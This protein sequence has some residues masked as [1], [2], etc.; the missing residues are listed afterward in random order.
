DNVNSVTYGAK[1]CE[2]GILGQITIVGRQ[3][4][5]SDCSVRSIAP[6]QTRLRDVHTVREHGRGQGKSLGS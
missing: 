2:I 3:R 4:I 5:P 1:I 6:R